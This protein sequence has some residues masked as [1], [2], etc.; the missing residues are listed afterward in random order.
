MFPISRRCSECPQSQLH[1]AGISPCTSPCKPTST[2]GKCQQP[3]L[4]RQR[5]YWCH[6]TLW[7]ITL[8]SHTNLFYNYETRSSFHFK[9]WHSEE[10]SNSFQREVH[11]IFSIH[12]EITSRICKLATANFAAAQKPSQA[13]EPTQELG[14]QSE[15]APIQLSLNICTLTQIYAC[16][17]QA[18]HCGCGCI[19]SVT[20]S[21]MNRQSPNSGLNSGLQI[22]KAGCKTAPSHWCTFLKPVWPNLVYKLRISLYNIWNSYLDVRF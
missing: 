12:E 20:W 17:Q 4:C 5:T 2:A 8:F 3:P 13:A 6:K 15:A 18:L 9:M 21:K 1:R 10:Q 19:S 14:R 7:L 11:M 22:E 16:E